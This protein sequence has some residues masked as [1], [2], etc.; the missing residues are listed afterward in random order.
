M[1]ELLPFPLL[2]SCSW[3]RGG[4]GF[5]FVH[6]FVFPFARFNFFSLLFSSCLGRTREKEGK[7]CIHSAQANRSTTKG[8]RQQREILGG[9]QGLL[10]L[11]LLL[12][13][14]SIDSFLHP[15]LSFQVL[16]FFVSFFFFILIFS[17]LSFPPESIFFSLSYDWIF[18]LSRFFSSSDFLLGVCLSSF[19]S[20]A[21]VLLASSMHEENERKKKEEKEEPLLFF[22]S[23]VVFL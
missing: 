20:S 7:M 16:L 21:E 23:V 3:F 8:R 17:S 22:F 15:V 9:I 18:H 5:F 6:S 14:E 13:T 1:S 10:L 2:R 11:L 4:R 12:A 19:R